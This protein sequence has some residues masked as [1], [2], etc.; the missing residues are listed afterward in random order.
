MALVCKYDRHRD[1]LYD[2]ERPPNDLADLVLY[3]FYVLRFIESGQNLDITFNRCKN[4]GNGFLFQIK[5]THAHSHFK[6]M[7]IR[8]L[9]QQ[10]TK[11]DFIT[12]SELS[13][14]REGELNP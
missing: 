8:I 12:K 2:L 11:I 14:D 5:N 3:C 10:F 7:D 4:C 9:R 6:F 13:L 1:V